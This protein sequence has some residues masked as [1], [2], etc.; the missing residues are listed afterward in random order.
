MESL[1][2]I[3]CGD[4]NEEYQVQ[5]KLIWWS[6]WLP[7]ACPSET[8]GNPWHFSPLFDLKDFNS[9][10]RINIILGYSLFIPFEFFLSGFNIYTR[11]PKKLLASKCQHGGFFLMTTLFWPLL[12][13]EYFNILMNNLFHSIILNVFYHNYKFGVIM[14]SSC[15]S[16]WPPPLYYGLAPCWRKGWCYLD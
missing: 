8:M 2:I 3:F 10:I 14:L 5:G 13:L 6:K 11:F 7:Q 9:M 16:S 12:D 15:W 4:F 1:V